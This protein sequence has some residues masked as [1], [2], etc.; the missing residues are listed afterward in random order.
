MSS[1]E[2]RYRR[3]LAWYPR[4]HRA[5]YED[6]MVGVLLASAEP[7]QTKPGL[8]ERADLYWGGLKLHTRRAFGRASAPAWRDALAVAV[9]VGTLAV[10]VRS[11]TNTAVA[12]ASGYWTAG[13]FVNLLLIVTV[14]A[15]VLGNWRRLAAPAAWL[16]WLNQIFWIGWDNVASPGPAVIEGW[17]LL[18]LSAAV[19]LTVTREPRRGLRLVGPL[20]MLSLAV[21]ITAVTLWDT[22]LSW[23]GWGPDPIFQ[24]LPILATCAIA[25]GY[26]LFSD[27]GRRSLAILALPV[28]YGLAST[29][30]NHFVLYG[31]LAT[32][33]FG[34][35]VVPCVLAGWAMSRRRD[36]PAEGSMASPG[37]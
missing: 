34:L 33:L 37:R 24:A 8:G 19:T 6:E 29:E 14:V 17:M 11:L 31:W 5:A 3:L 16:L 15:G 4:D 35:A 18:V 13:H 23:L 36:N 28:L 22:S 30:T 27:V 20:P 32:V 1:L 12:V 10:L 2:H 25:C 21:L 9:V 7:D 26:A